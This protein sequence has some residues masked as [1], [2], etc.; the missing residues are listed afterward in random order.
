[1]PFFFS[2]AIFSGDRPEMSK[3]D[4]CH[5][6]LDTEPDVLVPPVLLLRSGVMWML[7]WSN[8][9]RLMMLSVSRGIGRAGCWL[10]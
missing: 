3:S 8:D 7:C 4:P 2:F 5:S 6:V 9:V 10:R 1:M